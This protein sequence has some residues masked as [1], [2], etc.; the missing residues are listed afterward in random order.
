VRIGELARRTGV[1]PELLRAWE[2]RYD[3][4]QPARSTGGYRLYSSVDEQRV[5]RMTQLLAT[6]LSA[7]EAARQALTMEEAPPLAEP[8]VS[9]PIVGEI[10]GHLWTALDMFDGSGAHTALDQLLASVSLEGA[11][12]EVI[13]PYLHDLGD[14][15]ATGLAS[16][17]QEHFA[18]NLIRGRL[19]GLARDW[20]A[21]DGPRAVLACPPGEAHD[22]G[23]IIFGLL[24]ARRGWRVT[25]LGAD[26]PFDT[27][28]D[29]IRTIRPSLLV[30]ATARPD[31]SQTHAKE[32]KSIAAQVPTALA[33]VTDEH[34]AKNSGAQVL[35]GD[36]IN[37]ARTLVLPLS[38]SPALPSEETSLPPSQ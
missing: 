36:I 9:R 12:A 15:W 5:R 16:V 13:I 28:R 25:F 21:G 10:A 7:A 14:R 34:A 30:L 35:A 17:A 24:I 20:G 6:G 11:L 8:A 3:L 22:L 18:S 29:S 31:H 38:Q 33:G 2:Q 27:L 23:L 19:L 32:I 26:T 1:S 37:A 4:L